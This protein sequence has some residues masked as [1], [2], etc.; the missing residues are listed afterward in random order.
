[1]A[2]NKADYGYLPRDHF[3]RIHLIEYDETKT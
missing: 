2:M 1:M 3:D